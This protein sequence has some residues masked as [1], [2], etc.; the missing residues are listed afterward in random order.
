MTLRKFLDTFYFPGYTDGFAVVA[1]LLFIFLMLWKTEK[2]MI[3]PQF[4]E[5][6]MNLRKRIGG[7]TF[8]RL[9]CKY[10]PLHGLDYTGTYFVEREK[11]HGPS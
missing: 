2:K 10:N 9:K 1:L 6:C 7:S 11:R 5:K 8:C 4:C 3:L